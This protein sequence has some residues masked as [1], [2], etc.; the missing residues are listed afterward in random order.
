VRLLIGDLPIRWNGA[1][2]CDTPDFT[3]VET[4]GTHGIVEIKADNQLESA[5]VQSKR[6]AAKRWD[7][8]VSAD[9][10]LGIRWRYLLVSEAQIQTAKGSW[11][12]LKA[13]E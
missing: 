6:Q 12:A 8:R 4:A 2:K 5:D 10:S 13:N 7:N 3:A 9:P 11:A 1:G